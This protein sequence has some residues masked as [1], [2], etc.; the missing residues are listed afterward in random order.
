VAA[1]VLEGANF[2]LMGDL[3]ATDP[4]GFRVKGHLDWHPAG[5]PAYVVD[6]SAR[7]DLNILNVVAREQ[8]PFR[9]DVSGQLRDLANHFHW[10]ASVQVLQ[11][12]LRSFE[13]VGLGFDFLERLIHTCNDFVK[14]GQVVG[15][16]LAQSS[17]KVP[18]G[19]ANSVDEIC[20]SHSDS[21]KSAL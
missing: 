8:S 5:Q 16:N 11:F 1:G 19:S 20:V 9:T 3:L 7:G 4:I 10:V 6:G 15:A 12:E 18:D 17:A 2:I 21:E 13:G 14:G